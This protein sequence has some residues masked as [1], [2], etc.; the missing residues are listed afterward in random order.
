[1]DGVLVLINEAG[2]AIQQLRAM[3]AQRDERI[4]ELEAALSKAVPSE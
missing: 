1:M 4:V 2:V 3:V